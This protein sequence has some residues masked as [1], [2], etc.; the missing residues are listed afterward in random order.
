MKT[1][2]FLRSLMRISVGKLQYNLTDVLLCFWDIKYSMW[3]SIFS[4]FRTNNTAIVVLLRINGLSSFSKNFYIKVLL[5]EEPENFNSQII[6]VQNTDIISV[7]NTDRFR[8][9]F[10]EKKKKERKQ[11][12]P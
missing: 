4:N 9:I 11:K 3:R 10:L 12:L 6:S 8:W 7:Q 5:L 1:G 2:R